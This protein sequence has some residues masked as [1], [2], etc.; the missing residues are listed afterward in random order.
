MFARGRGDREAG[1]VP[2]QRQ[3]HVCGSRTKMGTE[4]C[5]FDGLYFRLCDLTLIHTFFLK[6]L[7]HESSVSY[8]TSYSTFLEGTCVWQPA[9]IIPPWLAATPQTDTSSGPS[10]ECAKRTRLIVC[11]SILGHMYLIMQGLFFFTFRETNALSFYLFFIHNRTLDSQKS[12][13]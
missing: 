5:E 7:Q 11:M 2:V 4:G 3:E 13:L 9:R 12:G 6:G 1:G 10:S 8:R